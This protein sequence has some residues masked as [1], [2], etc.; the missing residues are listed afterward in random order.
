MS[1]SLLDDAAKNEINSILDN[2]HDTFKR[3]IVV[4]VRET[5]T[6]PNTSYNPLYGRNPST[7][8]QIK[9]T[10]YTIS[11]RIYYPGRMLEQD[12]DN[13]LRL[14]D[15]QGKVR[16]KITATDLSLVRKAD[17][18]EIDNN[19]YTLAGDDHVDGPFGA[20][21]YMVYLERIT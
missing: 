7:T 10:P 4:Y 11:A 14:P 21:Y 19:S 3:N 6:V 20:R 13:R 16:L 9:L 1:S 17:R 2:L 18:I 15:S 12:Q 5:I 8:T